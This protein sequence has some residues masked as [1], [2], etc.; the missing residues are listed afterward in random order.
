MLLPLLVVALVPGIAPAL[1]F[2]TAGSPPPA[3]APATDTGAPRDAKSPRAGDSVV[4][5]AVYNGRK[6]DLNVRIPRFDTD[7]AVDGTLSAPVWQRAAVLNGFSEFFPVDGRQASDSTEVY[8]WYSAT[9]IYFGV[10]AFEAHGAVHAT[11]ANRDLID[12]DDNVELVLTPFVHGRHAVFLGVNP[13]GVQEDGTITEG[14]LA[15]GYNVAATGPPP[16]DL[17]A[18]FVYE[19]KGHLHGLRL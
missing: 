6:G 4:A 7:I 15:T 1:A 11:L 12:G 8:V 5:G 10:R 19:S 14:V 13:F 17:S 16:V 3:V 2:Q 18:D 9:A